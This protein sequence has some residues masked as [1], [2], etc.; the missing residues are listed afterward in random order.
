MTKRI[1]SHPHL[2][3]SEHIEQINKA[4]YGI[5]NWHSPETITPSIVNT[6]Q[7][8]VLLHDL[9]KGTTAFQEY[10]INPADYRGARDEKSHTTLSLIFTVAKAIDENW[11]ELETFILAAAAKGHHGRLPTV[12]E[13]QFD[14]VSC[15]EWDIDNFA[16]GAKARL[17][18]K[19]LNMVNHPGITAETGIDLQILR[20]LTANDDFTKLLTKL[21]RFL[22]NTIIFTLLSLPEREAVD[23]RLR[24]QLVFSIFLEADKAF[25]AVSEPAHYLKR[26]TRHW[27][28]QW[29][30]RY[31]GEPPDTKTNRLRLQVRD[32]VLRVIEQNKTDRVYSLTAPTGSGK[33]LLAATWAFSLRE[34]IA[35]LP[36]APPRIIVVL[37][38]LSI[39]DQTIK[40]YMKLLQT[41]GYEADGAWLLTS[42]SLADRH[43]AAWVEKDDEPFFVDTWRSELIIT[44]YDQFLMSLMDPRAKYQMRFHNLCDALIV[45]DEVQ[46][47]P[48]KL[49][50][51]LE[52]ILN[53]LAA[54][55]NSKILL[56]S[57]TLP[58]F[59][60]NAIPLL[61]AYEKYF[62]QFKRYKLLFRLKDEL[63]IESFSEELEKRLPVWLKE[64]RRVLI[65][66][67]TRK[68]A[69]IV[70]DVLVDLI[71]AEHDLPVYF[72]SA[73]VTPLDRLKTIEKIKEGQ[74]GIVVSTQCIEAGVN[75]DMD[76]VIR[77]FAPLDNLIQIAGRCNREGKKER[78]QVEIIDLTDEE[79][80]RY[81]EM[82]YDPVHLQVT[83][84][85]IK[86][87]PEMPEENVL[88][89]SN[90]YFN[91][92]LDKKDTGKVHLKRFAR[93]QDDLP[94]HELLRGK[95]HRQHT[96]LV[97]EEDP[98]LQEEMANA[99]SIADR[100]KRREAWR[101][102]AGRI[103]MVS[104]S[105]YAHPRFQPQQIANEYLGHWLLR[106]GYYSSDCGLLVEGIVAIL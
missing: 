97:I 80:N 106:D 100:W 104:V 77:D 54:T 5:G 73:D 89:L 85:L 91:Q 83:R 43:Y 3:L 81:S 34:I 25:L 76:L 55:G 63:S 74:P 75:I 68:S 46:S 98:S 56:M 19:Q 82:I 28:V 33:T 4:I 88:D 18:K 42:H 69:R 8:L 45:M 96:F 13:R 48:C 103:A 16:G 71:K 64:K 14:G 6:L 1:N 87:I 40:D 24:A 37:P 49:W 15:P 92:L 67:N 21:K 84:E 53:S 20:Q 72:I 29:I 27:Q 78:C 65:T 26:E 58:P 90:R 35:S 70:R 79:G 38:F 51:P 94:V 62:S 10:I 17:I 11:E 7:K 50:Q 39:I 52:S 102:L 105:V 101:K 99:N 93:W 41:G 36:E 23:F 44:T 22:T 30:D 66:L 61:P 32:D 2:F 12:P 9:G 86:D 31:I 59:V 47:L 95:E 60:K 57:A